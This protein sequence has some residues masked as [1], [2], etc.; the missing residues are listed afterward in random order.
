MSSAAIKRLRSNI[1]ANGFRYL[2]KAVQR[3]RR[4]IIFR[5]A[6]DGTNDERLLDA[7]SKQTKAEERWKRGRN[8]NQSYRC[9][10]APS[11]GPDTPA[12]RH[13]YGSGSTDAQSYYQN[14]QAMKS[15]ARQ[16]QH[17]AGFPDALRHASTIGVSILAANPL[18]KDAGNQARPRLHATFG[19]LS[20]GACAH[21]AFQVEMQTARY[22]AKMFPK[23]EW[24]HG[25]DPISEPD[26]LWGFLHIHVVIC[27]PEMTKNQLR[28]LLKQAY[29]GKN[30]VC[31]RRVKPVIKLNDGTETAGAQGYLEYAWRNEPRAD[32]DTPAKTAEAIIEFIRMN[33]TWD[34]RSR[35]VSYGK[36][37]EKSGTILDK[38]RV[39]FI[40]AQDRAQW[41]KDHWHQLDYAVRFLHTWLS[42]LVEV[43]RSD[44]EWVKAFRKGVSPI[45]DMISIFSNWATTMDAKDIDFS[46]YFPN[47]LRE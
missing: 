26:R 3:R 9:R 5:A 17:Q 43:Q 1:A 44:K 6:A 35:G 33:T 25:F 34:A 16:E 30:R 18:L 22:L 38:E 24:P 28:R 36:S 27:D 40:E 45:S 8:H 47:P 31:I 10:K 7:A 42:G 37:L 23:E 13:N 21:G 14:K 32:M 46:E 11:R 39:K 15:A 29:P 20:D 4:G 2:P 19:S 41:I 12:R